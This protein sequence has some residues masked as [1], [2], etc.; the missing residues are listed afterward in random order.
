MKGVMS[1]G[2]KEKHSSHYVGPYYFLR[3]TNVVASESKLNSDLSMLNLVFHVPL[4][5]NCI[6]DPTSIIPLQRIGMNKN[7]S[8]E[9]VLVEIF[10]RED[11]KL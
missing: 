9:E 3:F 5:K 1:F 6:N 8:Y 4:L 7:L 10:H 11:K 2:N